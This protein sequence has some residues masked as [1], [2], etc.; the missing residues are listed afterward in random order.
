MDAAKPTRFIEV[1][2]KQVSSS[3][4]GGGEQWCRGG[5]QSNGVHSQL[6]RSIAPSNSKGWQSALSYPLCPSLFRS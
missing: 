6:L 4:G 5:L 2:A 1:P 3:G